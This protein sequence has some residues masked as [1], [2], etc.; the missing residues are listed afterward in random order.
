MAAVIHDPIIGAT[1]NIVDAKA[2]LT[3]ARCQKCGCDCYRQPI[4]I[5][6]ELEDLRPKTCVRCQGET[7]NR[8]RVCVRCL[9]AGT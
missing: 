7:H 6:C 3:K 4:C 5:D 9:E 2:K 1:R 8:G